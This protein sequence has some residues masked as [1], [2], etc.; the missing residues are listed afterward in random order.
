MP[1]TDRLGIR[2]AG[3]DEIGDRL[4]ENAIKA[5]GQ[6]IETLQSEGYEFDPKDLENELIGILDANVLTKYEQTGDLIVAVA[7]LN[8]HGIVVTKKEA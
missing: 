7:N 8:T 3:I 5:R 2:E 4:T 6:L 1:R